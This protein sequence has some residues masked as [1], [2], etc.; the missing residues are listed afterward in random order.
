MPDELCLSTTKN[1]N[2]NDPPLIPTV[3]LY[4]LPFLC[5]FIFSHPLYFS[6][7]LFFSP[8]L[9][10]FIFL[11]SPLFFTTTLLL[12]LSFLATTFPHSKK[13]GFIQTVLDKLR[14]K[15]ND[16]D[17][18]DQEF[19]N[20]EDF[21]I[22]KI[23][24]HDVPSSL[25]TIGD[26]DHMEQVSVMEVAGKSEEEKSLE[27]LFEEL[28]LFEDSIDAI[29]M[30]ETKMSSDLVK[31]VGELQKPEAVETGMEKLEG[32]SM[33][34]PAETTV[35]DEYQKTVPNPAETTI[36]G[37]DQK[38]VPNSAET[39]ISGEEQKTVRNPF[40]MKSNSWRLDSCSSFGSYG[41]MRKEKE[42]KRTL[43]CKLF[44]ERHNSEGGEEGMDSLWEAYETDHS[45]T[46]SKNKKDAM[47]KH[48]KTLI[49]NKTEFKYFDDDLDEEDDEDEFMMSNGQLCCLKALK[50]SAGK[51]NLGMGKPNLVKISKALKG[52]GWLHHVGSKNGK[53][54]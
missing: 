28:D 10:K 13:L 41:S 44:E 7:F 2:N 20:F 40:G 35:S 3:F 52:F 51:M 54:I 6:Y 25:I 16:V 15:L 48:K 33:A 23:V 32:K 22:Y 31:V 4:D 8:Y 49:K 36:S 50:L 37:E 17:E 34:V 19:C 39:T 11:F 26:D 53:R 43:A 30:K 47:V 38:T 46:K 27:K 1:N 24:F 45:T 12:L 9:I 21:E 14:S 5:S 18:E 42:W 29:E